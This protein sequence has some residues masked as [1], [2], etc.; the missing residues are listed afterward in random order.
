MSEARERAEKGAMA[1]NFQRANTVEQLPWNFNEV[2]LN[3]FGADDDNA[4]K[5]YDRADGTYEP[6][7]DEEQDMQEDDES[8]DEHPPSIAVTEAPTIAPTESTVA[9]PKP[10]PTRK[11][12]EKTA[13]EKANHARFMKFTRSIKRV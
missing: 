10:K 1:E 12:R 2:G 6:D 13:Q 9:A 8:S 4:T 5:R 7:S 3:P 11:R